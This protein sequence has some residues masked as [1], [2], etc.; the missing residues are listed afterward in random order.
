MTFG[1]DS[2]WTLQG[3]ETREVVKVMRSKQNNWQEGRMRRQG[4]RQGARNS[5]QNGVEK[6]KEIRIDLKLELMTATEGVGICLFLCTNQR[7]VTPNIAKF[8]FQIKQQ[9]LL[10]VVFM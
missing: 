2:P 8:N 1:R 7:I 4:E 3:E 5:Q 6:T 9:A 10:V